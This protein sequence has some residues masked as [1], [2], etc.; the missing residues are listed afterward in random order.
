MKII[1]FFAITLIVNANILAENSVPTETA[2]RWVTKSNEYKAVCLQTYA[3]AEEKIES[4][5]RHASE[6][7][8]IVVDIDETVLNNGQYQIELNA[9]KASHSQEAWEEWVNRSEA[10]PVP[11]AKKF[12]V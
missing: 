6:P 8:A 4:G 5:A 2:I 10:L 3:M 7:W 1:S 12:I 9:K 11:G